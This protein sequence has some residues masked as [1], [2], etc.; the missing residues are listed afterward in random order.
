MGTEF[1]LQYVQL[2]HYMC[3]IT[4]S[5]S[6]HSQKGIILCIPQ[7]I[8][9]FRRFS[10]QLLAVK[11]CTFYVQPFIKSKIIVTVCMKPVFRNP[12]ELDMRELCHDIIH[13]A[14]IK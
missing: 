4:N 9:T 11:S 7:A 8:M 1:H 13:F 12:V 14:I 5:Y 3:N 2:Y 10:G 6:E